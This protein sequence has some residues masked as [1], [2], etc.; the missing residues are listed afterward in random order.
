MPR[1]LP[2]R[3]LHIRHM[4]FKCSTH[5]ASRRQ[6]VRGREGKAAATKVGKSVSYTC[7]PVWSWHSRERVVK[8]DRHQVKEA[9]KLRPASNAQ[10]HSESLPEP[11]PLLLLPL[12]LSSLLPLPPRRCSRLPSFLC[13]RLLPLIFS[14]PLP[15]CL[16]FFSFLRLQGRNGEGGRCDGG[17]VG[18]RWVHRAVNMHQKKQLSLEWSKRPGIRGAEGPKRCACTFG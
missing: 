9:H 6:R 16:A 12:P 3:V 4:C 13:R 10:L 11:P 5:C 7:S 2:K 15:L 8:A 18:G 14:L 17:R 1:V